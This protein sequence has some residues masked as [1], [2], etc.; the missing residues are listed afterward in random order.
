MVIIYDITAED[1]FRSVQPWLASIQE[2]VSDPIPIMLLGN[3]SD[4]DDEREVQ[5]KEAEMLAQ[6]LTPSVAIKML[7]FVYIIVHRNT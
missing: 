5:M 3:K 2:A 6:V 1:S 4:K 7:L